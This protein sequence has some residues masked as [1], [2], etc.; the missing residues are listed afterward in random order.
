ME[1]ASDNCLWGPWRCFT[2]LIY[3]SIYLDLMILWYLFLTKASY[4]GKVVCLQTSENMPHPFQSGSVILDFSHDLHTLG[5]ILGLLQATW[6]YSPHFFPRHSL[7]YSWHKVSPS[8]KHKGEPVTA[9]TDLRIC[10]KHWG[11]W[12]CSVPS[13]LVEGLVHFLTFTSYHLNSNSPRLLTDA[14]HLLW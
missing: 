12:T 2:S 11:R 8:M 6:V 5:L 1:Q 7:M 4:S 14:E 10:R 13:L 9:H 3:S